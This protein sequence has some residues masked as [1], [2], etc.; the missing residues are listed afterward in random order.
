MKLKLKGLKIAM[1]LN[2][3]TERYATKGQVFFHF[4]VQAET[5]DL[6]AIQLINPKL[7][8]SSLCTQ[9]IG[10]KWLM[11]GLSIELNYPMYNVLYM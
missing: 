8:W 2:W 5:S 10:V 1:L 4:T 7:E 11:S 9:K 3:N 6:R